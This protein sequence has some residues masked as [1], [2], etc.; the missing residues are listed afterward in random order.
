MATTALLAGT[1]AWFALRGGRSVWGRMLRLPFAIALAVLGVAISRPL[2]PALQQKI[3]TDAEM[4]SLQLV[5]VRPS[6]KGRVTAHR[7]L[8]S[9]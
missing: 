5:E 6:L 7:V 2:G 8:T 9:A 1:L 3:T 4:G